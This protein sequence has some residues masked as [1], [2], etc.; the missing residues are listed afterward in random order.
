MIYFNF[1]KIENFSDTTKKV[2]S[3]CLKMASKT[4]F[5]KIIVKRVDICSWKSN[6]LLKKMLS[7]TKFKKRFGQ[8]WVLYGKERLS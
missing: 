2:A 7:G 4:Y 3:Q 8:K 1:C 6:K 5:D